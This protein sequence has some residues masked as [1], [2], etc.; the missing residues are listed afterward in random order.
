MIF[1]KQILNIYRKNLFIRNDN[2]DGCDFYNNR[3]FHISPL[4]L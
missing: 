4:N 1:E 2:A 3:N